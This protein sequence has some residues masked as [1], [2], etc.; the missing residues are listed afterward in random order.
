MDEY[1]LDEV[2]NAKFDEWYAGILEKYTL[3]SYPDVWLPLVPMEP[4]FE[5]VEID[6][7]AAAADIPTFHIISDEDEESAAD[8]LSNDAENGE[9][10]IKEIVEEAIVEEAIEEAVEEAIAEEVIEE[11]IVEEVIEEAIKNTEA[12]E[13]MLI[14]TNDK[15]NK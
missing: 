8:L 3:E 11:A 15:E 13:L 2:R 10:M 4:A 12:E 1:A 5:P 14:L 6:P 7:E 9:E